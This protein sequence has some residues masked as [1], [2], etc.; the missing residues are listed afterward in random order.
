[1]AR[2][3]RAAAPMFPGCDVSTST[4]RTRSSRAEA[5]GILYQQTVNGAPA[6]LSLGAA[7]HPMLNIAV[8]AARAAGRII[9]RYLDRVDTL[10]V[11]S[12]HLNEFVTKVDQEAE[13]IIISEI[14]KAYPNHGI[15]GEFPR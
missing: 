6:P 11:A 9:V 3:A 14:H 7:M 12:K 4:T 8:S 5:M 2:I 15:L 10:D 13:A 1:M